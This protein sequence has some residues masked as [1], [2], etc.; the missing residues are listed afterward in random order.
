M[1]VLFI[2]NLYPNIQ[3]PLRAVYNKQKLA[4]LKELCDITIV[5]PVF[6]YPFKSLFDKKI[7]H[8]P[9]KEMIDGMDVYH[10]R[11]LYMPRFLR[12]TYG[13]LY[14]Q[15]IR[16]L[17]KKL[18]K[19]LDF[20]V[21]YAS[22]L[23]PDG[24]AAMRIAED[25]KIPF[26]VEALG[27]DVNV[28]TKSLL[29]RKIIVNVLKRSEAVVAASEDLKKKIVNLGISES[30]IA[31]IYV[32][33]DR[34]LFF[35]RERCSAREDLRIKWRGKVSLFIGNLVAIKGVGYLLKAMMVS[36]RDDWMLFIIGDGPQRR[37]IL[38]MID[39]MGLNERVIL[40]GQ[41]EHNKIQLWMNA[42]DVV[43]L[44]SLAEGVPNVILEAAACGIPVVASSVGGVPEVV[45][46][47]TGVLVRPGYFKEFADAIDTALS[48]DWD[49]CFINRQVSRFSWEKNARELMECLHS[50]LSK[51]L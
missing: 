41:I 42:A 43:C 6:C 51:K 47:G 32:G 50:S 24:F 16:S 10:P 35:P 11:A 46:N 20:D 15:S 22:W 44:P 29:R 48:R 21:I 14:Y 19:E 1:K 4:H 36:R 9:Y 25:L 2:S 45:D 28:Y 38:G 3:E 13:Y 17:I 18:S 12:S 39:S 40:V 7:E 5:A 23:Y 33:I 34:G 49:R 30:K 26:I 37:S 27:S 31:V 8:I